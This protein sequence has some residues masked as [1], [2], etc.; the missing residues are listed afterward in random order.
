MNTYEV[1]LIIDARDMTLDWLDRIKELGCFETV[2][3]EDGIH[4]YCAFLPYSPSPTDAIL[5]VYNTV[6][7]AGFKINGIIWKSEELTK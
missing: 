5:V 7:D 3:E 4:A 1:K 6:N 2:M